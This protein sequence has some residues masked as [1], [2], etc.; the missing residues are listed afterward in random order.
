MRILNLP[1][2]NVVYCNMEHAVWKTW[3]DP[4]NCLW[5]VSAKF[6][7]TSRFSANINASGYGI[8]QSSI[9][10]YMGAAAAN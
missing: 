8:Q 2:G 9:A 6:I 7:I 1:L 4:V 3:S 10:V 5:Q